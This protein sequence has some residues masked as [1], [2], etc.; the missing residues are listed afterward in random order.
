MMWSLFNFHNGTMS[1][2]NIYKTVLSPAVILYA[3]IVQPTAL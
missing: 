2:G 1:S 3:L